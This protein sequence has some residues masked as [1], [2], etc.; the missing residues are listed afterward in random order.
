[1]AVQFESCAKALALEEHAIKCKLCD[2]V[3]EGLEVV[4]VVANATHAG[5]DVVSI[6]PVQTP[7]AGSE[8]LGLSLL[9]LAHDL[10]EKFISLKSG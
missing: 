10:V 8:D 1:M 2:E 5:Q 9:D 4:A 3:Q 6:G 7:V